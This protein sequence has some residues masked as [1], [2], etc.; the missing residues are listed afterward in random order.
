MGL[1]YEVPSF[2]RTYFEGDTAEK[3]VV[4][5]VGVAGVQLLDAGD[6]DRPVLAEYGFNIIGSFVCSDEARSAHACLLP[7][8]AAVLGVIPRATLAVLNKCHPFGV[9]LKCSLCRML[10][11]YTLVLADNAVAEFC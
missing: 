9:C 10:L 4:V 6:G 3:P 8:R 2:G 11:P 5:G 1:M 7:A